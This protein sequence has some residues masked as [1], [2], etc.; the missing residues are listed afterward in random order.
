MSDLNHR[1]DG[2]GGGT[3]EE[4]VVV[5]RLLEQAG[6]R[7]EVPPADLAAIKSAFRAEWRAHLRRRRIR[8]RQ[9]RLLALAAALLLAAGIGG[10]W[11]SLRP[12][13]GPGPVAQVV[14]LTGEVVFQAPAEAGSEPPAP[15][16]AGTSIPVASVVAVGADSSGAVALRLETGP[17]VRID[18]GS[19]VRLVSASILQ[20]ERGAVYVDSGPD[21]RRGAGVEIQTPLGVVTEVGTQFEVRLLGVDAALLRVRVREGEV[22]IEQG[23]AARS[24]AGGTEVTVDAGG[25]FTQGPLATHGAPWEWVSKAAPRLDIEGRTLREFLDWVAR[26]TGWEIRYA[27]PELAASADTILL[28]GTLGNLSPDEAPAVVLP[29]AGL[30]SEVRDGVLVVRA[31]RG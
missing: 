24:A 20:L 9:R 26:E 31:G 22:R 13:A 8:R 7:P 19:R 6:P 28:H 29:G 27:D 3:A 30:R 5:R 11:W 17:S 25:T 12:R 10:W 23:E 2:D 16:S 15:L 14:R 4:E 21:P 18:S 1:M